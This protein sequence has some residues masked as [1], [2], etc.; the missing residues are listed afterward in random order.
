MTTELRPYQK[1]VI[2]WF[3]NNQKRR[4]LLQEQTGMGKTEIVIEII[5]RYIKEGKTCIF[6][7]HTIELREQSYNRFINSGIDCGLLASGYKF[8]SDKKCYIS[9]IQTAQQRLSNNSQDATLD[10]IKNVDLIIFDETHRID[11]NQWQ[12]IQY[13][14]SNKNVKQLGLS[15]TPIGSN[16]K[17]LGKFYDDLHCG[18]QLFDAV[19]QGYLSDCKLYNKPTNINYTELEIDDYHNEKDFKVYELNKITEAF[20]RLKING[21]AVIE[22]EKVAKN[23][24]TLVFCNSIL[25]CQKVKDEFIAKNYKAEIIHSNLSKQERNDVLNKYKN[26][27]IDIIINVRIFIEGIDIPEIECIIDL[28][29]TRSFRLHRQKIGRG[30]RIK[31]NN[32]PLILIDCAD[33]CNRHEQ[34]G[35]PITSVVN[36]TLKDFLI[37]NR[38]SGG[39]NKKKKYRTCE[40]CNLEYRSNLSKCPECDHV[41]SCELI[42]EEIEMELILA[43]R[44]RQQLRENKQ[45]ILE[46]D[47]KLC[48]S[49]INDIVKKHN[50]D[51]DHEKIEKFR[52]ML[53]DEIKKMID[54]KYPAMKDK[55]IVNKYAISLVYRSLLEKNLRNNFAYIYDGYDEMLYIEFEN[56]LANPLRC[57]N[58][59]ILKSSFY[60]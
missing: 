9:M 17:G 53:S 19:Q 5:K 57:N 1:E 33:N 21:N 42:P 51:Y 6:F 34:D 12:E 16:G 54:S 35:H 10:S 44:T 26:N 45:K 41:N 23:K 24:K 60:K 31:K 50:I 40:N 30:L 18:M 3:F 55:Y 28:S 48:Q 8:E 49:L 37:K 25:H 32:N 13:Y 56:F 7:T 27:E 58:M 22:W 46:D 43:E 38:T 15:A 29:P 39:G 36:Y 20:D 59:F 52:T 11:S 4:L 47:V 2:E 14:F